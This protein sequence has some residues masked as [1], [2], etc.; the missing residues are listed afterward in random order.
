MLG[1]RSTLLAAVIAAPA[2]WA[3]ALWAQAPAPSPTAATTLSVE[4]LLAEVRQHWYEPDLPGLEDRLREGAARGLLEELNRVQ[5]ERIGGVAARIDPDDRGVNRMYTPDEFKL[6][7]QEVSGK[8]G[9][10]GLMLG[11]PGGPEPETNAAHVEYCGPHAVLKLVPGMPAEKSGVKEGDLVKS[12][13]GLRV[14]TMPLKDL[15]LKLRGEPGSRVK[16]ALERAGKPVDLELERVEIKVPA[17]QI[18]PRANGTAHL[19]VHEFHEGALDELKAALAKAKEQKTWGLVID[20][21]DNPGGALDVAI[22][23][24]KLFLAKGEV[25]LKT[26]RH[27]EAETVHKQDGEPTWTGALVVLVNGRTR[28]S[29]E[30][31][32]GALQ[33]NKKALI[34]GEK[35]FGKGTAETL[36]ALPSGHAIKITTLVLYRPNGAATAK[37]GLDPDVPIAVGRGPH[38]WPLTTAADAAVPDP[39]EAAFRI[40]EFGRPR[41]P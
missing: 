30:I 36:I 5:A 31:F 18:E 20:L 23:A 7:R 19:T 32:A 28:S 15:V 37:G 25:I 4:A 27:G 10:L 26:R 35:T 39:V 2:L 33:D 9:G 13:D 11:P 41:A 16:L 40:L 1:F 21:R 8:F 14:E 6:F 12:V 24:C 3:P 29:A 38:R 22:A 17:V 34:V